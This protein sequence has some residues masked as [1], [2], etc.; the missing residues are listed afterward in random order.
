[1]DNLAPVRAFF[2]ELI[3]PI[4]KDAVKE[5]LPN[6][7]ESGNGRKMPVAEVAKVYGI[8]LSTIY[9]RFKTGQLTKYKQNGLTFV[10]VDELEQSMTE[11]KLCAV[12]PQKAGKTS[13]KR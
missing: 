9:L 11:E 6:A 8:G 5:A 4:V 7:D 2:K 10:D 1:M 3:T 13:S 12:L